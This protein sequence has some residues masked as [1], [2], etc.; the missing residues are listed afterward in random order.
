MTKEDNWTQARICGM[1][2]GNM[3]VIDYYNSWKNISGAKSKACPLMKRCQRSVYKLYE[4]FERKSDNDSL[5][6][7][8]PLDSTVQFIKDEYAYD[9]QS[10]IGEVGGTLGLLLGLSFLSI[11]D[12][13]DFIFQ[14]LIPLVN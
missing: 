2:E 1:K 7:I 9:K 3:S 8:R 13:I 10:F 5:L 4:N 6:I 11:F 14:K 12:F